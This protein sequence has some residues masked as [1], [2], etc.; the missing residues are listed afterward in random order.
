[1]VYRKFRADYL[2]TGTDLLDSH[3]V[4]VT[5]SEGYIQDVVN[6]SQVSED[7]ETLKGILS[8]G[9]INTH[10]HIELSH[11]QN[12]IP[13]KTGLT[14]FVYKVVTERHLDEE[15][16]VE[17]IEK[18]IEAMYKNGIAAVGDI[19][20]N[21]LAISSKK[22]SSLLY[23]NYIEVSGWNP[24]IAN[25][26]FEGSKLIYDQ[27]LA[28]GYKASIVPHAPYSVSAPLWEKITPY[29]S[30][31]IVTIH[32]QETLAEEEFF[33]KGKGDLLSM[34][35]NMRID[36][37]FFKAPGVSSIQ[38]FFKHLSAANSVILVHNTFIKQDDID[39]IN[40]HKPLR[41]TLS[42]CLCPNANKYIE[43]AFPPVLMLMKNNAHIVIGTDSLASNHELS[44]L[45]ELKTISKNCP[46]IKT[47]NLL[48][49]A[50]LNGAM[51]LQMNK[52]LGSF[53][54]GKKPGIVLIEN[55]N[56]D[57]LT[58]QSKARRIL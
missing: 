24:A 14:D 1:M 15:K 44:I 33:L 32:N 55:N 29:F 7:I 17:A 10:C 52:T 40:E 58:P 6:Q 3:F 31:K 27:Y 56:E 41:Q 36:N 30:G 47:E 5:D 39:F 23:Y 57:K 26:R 22:N 37:S 54:K 50:T 19:C 21:T 13:E 18:A 51:A 42:F 16:I 4:L 46:C 49:W 9:F 38:S 48:K 8:P 2:F 28:N 45:E 43:D 20:N 53:G 35:E 11:L 34:Y 25:E 12:K